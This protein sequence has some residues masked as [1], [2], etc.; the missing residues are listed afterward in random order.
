M[1]CKHAD[2]EVTTSRRD[3]LSVGLCWQILICEKNV[4][5]GSNRY[6]EKISFSTEFSSRGSQRKCWS[7]VIKIRSFVLISHLFMKRKF[8]HKHQNQS[9]L[10]NWWFTSPRKLCEKKSSLW[11][12]AVKGR[13]R[14]FRH[15]PF[16]LRMYRWAGSRVLPLWAPPHLG[17]VPD[18]SRDPSFTVGHPFSPLYSARL[19]FDH[20]SGDLPYRPIMHHSLRFGVFNST[21]PQAV[22]PLN[23][24]ICMLLM[25]QILPFQSPDE[26]FRFLS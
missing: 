26:E 20:S 12:K 10:K 4:K 21:P 22:T 1:A 13:F 25:L 2:A 5:E 6:F 3:Q 9:I 11:V 19:V 18:P 17:A 7:C 14:E 23:A 8:P 15:D 16:F 24:L